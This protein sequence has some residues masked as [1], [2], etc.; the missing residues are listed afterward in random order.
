MHPA[1]QT[2]VFTLGDRPAMARIDIHGHLGLRGVH[3]GGRRQTHDLARR[4]VQHVRRGVAGR[5]LAA[6]G[7]G[8]SGGGIE[9]YPPRFDEARKQFEKEYITHKLQ[10]NRGNIKGTAESIGLTRRALEY[11]R[12]RAREQEREEHEG[13]EHREDEA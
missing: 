3:A 1:Q 11:R 8:D 10:V 12:K 4:L 5:W 2:F 6:S 13:E 7:G 9:R